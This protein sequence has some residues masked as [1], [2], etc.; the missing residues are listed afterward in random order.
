M[1][2]RMDKWMDGWASVHQNM[3][4]LENTQGLFHILHQLIQNQLI[5]THNLI[6]DVNSEKLL[7]KWIFDFTIY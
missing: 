5:Y 7:L 6:L 4:F 3:I 2:G 1:D